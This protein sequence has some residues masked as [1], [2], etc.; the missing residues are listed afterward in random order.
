MPKSDRADMPAMLRLVR[1]I[2]VKNVFYVFYPPY[3]SMQVLSLLF[4]V[5][6]YRYLGDG[7][8][9]LRQILH[10]GKMLHDAYR[11]RTQSVP[12]LGRFPWGNFK[13]PNFGPLK[14]E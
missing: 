3:V 2:V 10:D 6:G 7:G 12:F 14:T 4:S 5:S 8:T 9:D 13:I 1:R 11:S